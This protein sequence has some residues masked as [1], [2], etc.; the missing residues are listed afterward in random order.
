MTKPLLLVTA[1]V[2]AATG[3]ALVLAPSAVVWVLVGSP[4]DTPPGVLVGR[5]AGAALF[6][7]GIACWLAPPNEPGRTAAGLVAPMLVYNVA[8]IVLLALGLGEGLSGI[9]FW[10][11]VL[12]HGVLAA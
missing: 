9:G 5:V 6:A 1:V 11:A 12:L 10:P 3:L 2:E 7:L 8:V 4:L